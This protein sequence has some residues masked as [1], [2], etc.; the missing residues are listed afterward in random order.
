[1]AERPSTSERGDSA[2]FLDAIVA[3]ALDDLSEGRLDVEAALR[4]LAHV[5]F[6]AGQRC[7]HTDTG[8]YEAWTPR[9][10]S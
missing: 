5:A 4:S 8:P 2:R 7:Q 1:M 3:Q 6:N 10:S 9:E